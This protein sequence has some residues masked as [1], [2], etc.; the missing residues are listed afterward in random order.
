MH[1][2]DGPCIVSK[3]V[4]HETGQKMTCRNRRNSRTMALHMQAASADY[5]SKPKCWDT[6]LQSGPYETYYASISY[7]NKK[8]PFLQLF[9]LLKLRPR[10]AD[11]DFVLHTGASIPKD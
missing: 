7:S 9:V 2:G 4:A 1:P 6:S 10:R 3:C 8:M 11:A 5:R